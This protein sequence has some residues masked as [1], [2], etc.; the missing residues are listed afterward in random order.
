VVDR[1]EEAAADL[2]RERDDAGVGSDDDRD[3]VD[4]DVDAAVTGPVGIVGRI[5]PADDRPDDGPRPGHRRVRSGRRRDG[6]ERE[7]ADRQHATPHAREA[8]GTR[9]SRP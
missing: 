9:R 1:Q 2:A 7:E 3:E 6:N 5:E 4:R 8:R